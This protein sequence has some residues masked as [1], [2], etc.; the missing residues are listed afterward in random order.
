MRHYGVREHRYKLIHFYN[1]DD[2]KDKR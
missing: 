2:T 1:S